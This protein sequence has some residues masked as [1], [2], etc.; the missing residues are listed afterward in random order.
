MVIFAEIYLTPNLQLK[1]PRMSQKKF[2]VPSVSSLMNSFH[3]ALLL[4][5]HCLY[6]MNDV[7]NA[8]HYISKYA[9]HFSDGTTQKTA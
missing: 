8:Y 3:Y 9:T 6:L 4:P 2:L 5:L 7:Q 1:L